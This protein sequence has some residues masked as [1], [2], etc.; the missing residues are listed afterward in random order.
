MRGVSIGRRPP[1]HSAPFRSE[2]W[3]TEARLIIANRDEP[4]QNKGHS[5]SMTVRSSSRWT[6]SEMMVRIGFQSKSNLVV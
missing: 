2:P 4:H 6:C 3:R 1:H 5:Q